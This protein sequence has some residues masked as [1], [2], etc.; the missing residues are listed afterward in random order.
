MSKF[1]KKK[2]GTKTIN[3][4]GGQAFKETTELELVSLLL[5]SFL[6]DKFYEKE[7]EQLERLQNLVG[8]LKDKKFAAKAAIYARTVFG[9]RSITHAL[10]G[11]ICKMV[12]GE[13]WVKNAVEKAVYRP[14]D[15][16]EILAY[17]RDDK[18]T[19]IPNSLKKGLRL[20]INKFD[21]Y[22]LAKYKGGGHEFKMVDLINLVHPKGS[23]KLAEIFKE[24]V[25]G[26]LK[27]ENTWERNLSDAG[28]K[29]KDI[30]D[31]NEKEE[32]LKEA[33][34]N[35]WKDMIKEKKIGT[36]ALLRNLRN[37]V[38]QSPDSIDDACELLVDEKKI[39]NSLILPFRFKTAMDELGKVD[40]SRKILT[41][42]SKALDISVS[43]VP[44]FDGKTLVVIDKSGSMNGKP[45]EIASI[46][47][48]IL[49][50]SN[51][52]D[53]MYFSEGT[54]N[55][56]LNT[57]DS[58]MTIAN[59]IEHDGWG[60]GTDFTVIFPALTKKY[61]RIII[62][63]DMQGWVNDWRGES[64]PIRGFRDYKIR[65]GINPKIYSFDLNGYGTLEF[66]ENDVFC[67]AGWSDKIFDVMKIMEQDRN[68]LIK[69]INEIE[70]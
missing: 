61:D 42:I 62:L 55:V 36:F 68:A 21:K 70:L 51:D 31:E 11:E 32:A 20:A 13:Q 59:E 24:L 40:G 50:K 37:I 25:E 38:Q 3:K 64:T 58:T 1:N 10:I 4:A 39:K 12:K 17:V 54:K 8:G 60:G 65:L 43:N 47:G 57:E 69:K 63:S 34:D 15:M 48:A 18:T 41:A 6:K 66:P 53:L 56:N 67:I 5:T 14:D 23:G 45:I 35:V 26:K 2:L 46:F 9:M 16:L 49:Y 27:T 33:K 22:S 30:E 19:P 28:Q 52:A 7:E 29:V 44:K